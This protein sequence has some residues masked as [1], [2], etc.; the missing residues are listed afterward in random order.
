MAPAP[1]PHVGRDVLVEGATRGPVVSLLADVD[2][3]GE[4]EGDVVALGGDVELEEGARVHGDVVA[5]G[6]L[7]RG[8]APVDGRVLGTASLGILGIPGA[9]QAAQSLGMRLIQV[10]VWMLAVGLLIALAP[11]LV[12]ES[13]T[14]L[15]RRPVRIVAVGVLALVVWLAVTALG[16]A[17]AG[18][19]LGVG[20]LVVVVAVILMAKLL[21]VAAVAWL[22]GRWIAPVLPVRLRGEAPRSGVALLCLALVALL[23][24]AGEVVWMAVNLAGI[25]AAVA[26]PLGRS[27]LRAA[28]PP[29][30]SR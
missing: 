8:R 16:V 13:G 26:A 15:A 12:R 27:M 18:T 22:G 29:L 1:A 30:T 7:V 23:P 21:G 24:L 4:V 11:R 19:P 14:E 10:G 17:F 28:L 3:R 9:G 20:V 2:V 25:G 6:G 5:L